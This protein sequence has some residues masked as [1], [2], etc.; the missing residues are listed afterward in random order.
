LYLA[1]EHPM[2]TRAAVLLAANGYIDDHIRARVPNRMHPGRVAREDLE[3][4][5]SPDQV[6]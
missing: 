3:Q 2:H 1:H 4:R 6:I 5:V